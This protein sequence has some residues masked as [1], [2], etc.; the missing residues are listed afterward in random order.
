MKTK[1]LVFHIIYV[2]RSVSYLL[3]FVESLLQW[4]DCSYRLVSNG[5]DAYEK[6]FMQEFCR[7]NPRLEFMVLPTTKPMA[8]QDALNYL[9][10]R[11]DSEIFSFLDSDIFACGP[12]LTEISSLLSTHSAV[13]GG[14]P[15]W[16]RPEDQQM[17]PSVNIACGEHNRTHT[18]LL[19]GCTFLAIYDNRILKNFM[20]AN[21]MGFEI[22]DWCELA[23]S[24]QSWCADR[25]MNGYWF[26]SGKALNLGLQQQ[27]CRIA[28]ADT[29]NLLHLGGLSFIAKRRWYDARKSSQ[30]FRCGI[31]YFARELYIALILRIKNDPVFRSARLPFL[32]R[33]RRYGPYFA[34]LLEALV[35]GNRLPKL[36]EEEEGDIRT[37]ALFATQQIITMMRAYREKYATLPIQQEDGLFRGK[38]H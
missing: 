1:D 34:D 38:N 2:P 11:A 16:L 8:H 17:S 26:D 7:N 22:R 31:Y 4:S 19:L 29:P 3:G 33:R 15:F 12:F 24:Q 36:P 28:V 9:Q 25:E 23:P 32:R 37:K 13:F 10:A 35:L 14:A 20:A 18:G 27:G 6:Q 21:G 30:F 5:C